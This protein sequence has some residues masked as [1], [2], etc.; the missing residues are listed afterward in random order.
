MSTEQ[1]PRT[2]LLA[3]AC[4][5]AA[6]VTPVLMVLTCLNELDLIAGPQSDVLGLL[7]LAMLAVT[8]G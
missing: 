5:A 6:L 1:R 8:L 7:T 2:S 4:F 3:W